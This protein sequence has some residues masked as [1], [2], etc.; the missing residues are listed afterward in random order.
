MELM[1][2]FSIGGDASISA[3]LRAAMRFVPI[4][5]PRIPKPFKFCCVSRMHFNC[6]ADASGAKIFADCDVWV[7]NGGDMAAGHTCWALGSSM[8]YYGS[9]LYCWL[10][11]AY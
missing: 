3:R 5:D 6:F 8:S 11:K 10:S 7:T 2:N 1:T 9:C 4:S